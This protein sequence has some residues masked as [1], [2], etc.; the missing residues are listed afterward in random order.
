M[1]SPLSPTLS[2]SP[3]ARFPL[4][5]ISPPLVVRL[6]PVNDNSPTVTLPLSTL[7][8][9]E[10]TSSVFPFRDIVLF[11]QDDTPC[12]PSNLKGARVVVETIASDS[13]TDMVSDKPK[14]TEMTASYT[15]SV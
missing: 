15:F 6:L 10:T 4:Q 2:L 13:D 12:Y 11:D 14:I 1:T 9:N 8:K 3:H 5:V 7:S